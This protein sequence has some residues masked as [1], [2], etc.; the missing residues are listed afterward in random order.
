MLN[1]NLFLAAGGRET[2]RTKW[3]V[4]CDHL[5]SQWLVEKH[6]PFPFGHP[7]RTELISSVWSG[8]GNEEAEYK[9]LPGGPSNK[10]EAKDSE[11]ST[12]RNVLELALNYSY[13]EKP[14]LI[15]LIISGGDYWERLL[16]RVWASCIRVA[17]ISCSADHQGSFSILF[18]F[19]I[20]LPFD[21]LARIFLFELSKFIRFWIET[22][23]YSHLFNWILG[24]ELAPGICTLWNTYL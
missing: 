6:C 11:E 2:I 4:D 12:V 10:K 5:F 13:I 8:N 16:E 17:C 9:L 24:G 20:L 19:Q 15:Y 22:E 23:L 1:T 7:P 21:I 3:W 18:L 14:H